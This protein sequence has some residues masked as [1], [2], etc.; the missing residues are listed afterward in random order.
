[1]LFGRRVWAAI[2]AMLDGRTQAVRAELAEAQRLRNEAEAMLAEATRARTEALSEAEAMLARSRAEAAH[3][4]EAAAAETAAAA[5]RR[6]RMAME[7]IEAAEKA[8][9]EDVRRTAADVATRAAV[10]VIE[11]GLGEDAQA[12]IL[13]RAI[14]DLPRALRAA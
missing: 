8:A 10:L 1:V 6:E 7:R 12:A 14:A 3:L 4:A 2:T 9:L 13:D 11:Q 5:K